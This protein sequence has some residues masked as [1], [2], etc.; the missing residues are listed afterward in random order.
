MTRSD[1]S[2]FVYRN[3]T[4]H[5]YLLLYDDDMILTDSSTQL[6]QR[7]IERLRSEFA[8][9]D[10]GAL[11]FFLSIDVQRGAD[12]FFL[13]QKR[14]AE[15]LLQPAGMTSSLPISTAI[16]SKA[17]V[18]ASSGTPLSDP[19]FYCSLTGGLQYLTITRPDISYA[20]QQ[21]CLHMHDPRD[22]HMALVKRIL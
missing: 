5:A 10:M 15:D 1:A 4:E 11:R 12:G 14:Y 19:S 3:G 6:L 2:L 22:V 18:S 20:V 8:I 21:T 7:I 16:I 13:S 9:K 17:K